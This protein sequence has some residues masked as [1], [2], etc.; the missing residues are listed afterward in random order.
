M[1]V[2]TN[3]KPTPLDEVMQL[4]ERVMGKLPN[5]IE[6]LASA[7]TNA[8]I[9]ALKIIEHIIVPAMEL[10]VS[11]HSCRVMFGNYDHTIRTP[12]SDAYSE[13]FPPLVMHWLREL[14]KQKGWAIECSGSSARIYPYSEASLVDSDDA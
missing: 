11:P 13:L 8:G 12:G 5:T 6:Y 2:E 10:S 3:T 9:A 14:L 1:S 4:R 7:D